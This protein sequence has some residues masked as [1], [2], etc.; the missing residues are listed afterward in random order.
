[1]RVKSSIWAIVWFVNDALITKLGWPVALPRF[2]SRPSERM[3]IV[4]PSANTHWSTCG[5]MLTRSTSSAAIRPAMSISLSK[6][7]MLPSTALCFMRRI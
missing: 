4:L 6:C 1:M 5:L 7:P 2:S 3:M